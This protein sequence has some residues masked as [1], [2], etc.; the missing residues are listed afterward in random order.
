MLVLGVLVAVATVFSLLLPTI[1][2]EMGQPA[3]KEVVKSP[4][5]GRKLTAFSLEPLTGD[6]KPATLQNLAGNI[7]IVNFWGTWCPPC[8]QEFPELVELGKELS[9]YPDVRLFLV[10]CEAGPKV[11]FEE[12]KSET[13]AFLENSNYKVPTYWDPGH[14]TGSAFH[15]IAPLQG[16]PT[17]FVL[18]RDSVIRGIW[19]GYHPGCAEGIRQLIL[20]LMNR[21]NAA[22]K[23]P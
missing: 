12:L 8:R 19:S 15:Q 16:L 2:N 21:E 22:E 14:K 7:V 13:Q 4:G 1:I 17:T 3:P 18:D 10:S 9:R 5:I 6:G 20:D 23:R 11:E